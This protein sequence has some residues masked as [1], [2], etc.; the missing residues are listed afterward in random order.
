[1]PLVYYALVTAERKTKKTPCY[2]KNEL[3][4]RITALFTNLNKKTVEIVGKRF[5][6]CLETEVEVNGN[7]FQLI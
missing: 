4:T 6:S 3:K 5:R 1:M 2:N 7:S